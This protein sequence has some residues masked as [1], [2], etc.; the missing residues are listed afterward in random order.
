MFGW[1]IVV[2]YEDIKHTIVKEA[3]PARCK[4]RGFSP[5]NIE[6]GY[7][8]VTRYLKRNIKSLERDCRL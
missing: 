4:F 1:A 7:T 2:D 5:D 3:Y 6:K 8:K